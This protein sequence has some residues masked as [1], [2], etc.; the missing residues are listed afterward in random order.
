MVDIDEQE[1][2]IV[3]TEALT[4]AIKHGNKEKISKKVVAEVR[5]FAD[6]L[7]IAITDEGAGFDHAGL[8]GPRGNGRKTQG[9]GLSLIRSF[10][11]EVQFNHSGNRITMVKFF[12]P[13]TSHETKRTI[14][15][16]YF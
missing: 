3:L 7:V 13:I 8:V 12:L 15:R 14:A 2:A 9:R 16:H 1:L 10:M 4:N 5:L 11:D 6:K